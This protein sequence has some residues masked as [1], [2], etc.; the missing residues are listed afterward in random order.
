MR[1]AAQAGDPDAAYRL[2]LVHQQGL[3]G[4]PR[5]PRLAA[6]YFE[7]AAAAGNPRAQFRLAQVLDAAAT[8]R[9]LGAWS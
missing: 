8:D 4:A 7:T 6:R 9:G 3:A 2:G 5:D 1:A